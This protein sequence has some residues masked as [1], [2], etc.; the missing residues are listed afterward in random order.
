MTATH[1]KLTIVS[2]LT[3]FRDEGEEYERTLGNLLE[4]LYKRRLLDLL[5]KNDKR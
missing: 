3:F 2:S 4:L 1:F 5:Y